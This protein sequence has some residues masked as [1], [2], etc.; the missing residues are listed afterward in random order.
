MADQ[1]LPKWHR[2]PYLLSANS[3]RF[4]VLKRPAHPP[5]IPCFLQPLRNLVP[6]TAPRTS[7]EPHLAVGHIVLNVKGVKLV[8]FTQTNRRVR[9]KNLPR[10]GVPSIGQLVVATLHRISH[11]AAAQIAV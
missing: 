3:H 4:A 9:V 1:S 7:P 2:S 10:V 8:R 5:T 6:A 11:G